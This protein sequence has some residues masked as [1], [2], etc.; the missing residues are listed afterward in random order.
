[1]SNDDLAAI[2]K[3]FC[4]TIESAGYQVGVYANLNWWNNYLTNPVFSQWS[5]W[6]AQYNYQCDYKGSYDIWQRMSKGSIPGIQGDVD[7]NFGY[8]DPTNL[9]PEQTIGTVF[10]ASIISIRCKRFPKLAGL[11]PTRW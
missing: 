4:T 9:Y 1:M 7:V 3:T 11:P 5:R 6:V 2:A 10:L 8:V